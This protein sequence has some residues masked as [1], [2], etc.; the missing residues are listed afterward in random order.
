VGVSRIDPILDGRF[1]VVDSNDKW[2]LL[3]LTKSHN[4]TYDTVSF[5]GMS[6]RLLV[7]G[8]GADK[9]EH[10]MWHPTV[11]CRTNLGHLEN[12]QIGN[13][14]SNERCDGG[15]NYGFSFLTVHSAT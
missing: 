3:I 4:T 13:I 8:G 6:R 5:F 12:E 14:S 11:T 9:I 7:K 1:I 10:Q 2:H 15:N